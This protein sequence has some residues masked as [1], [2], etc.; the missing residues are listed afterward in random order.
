VR[1]GKWAGNWVVNQGNPELSL[2]DFAKSNFDLLG[3][4]NASILPT[5]LIDEQQSLIKA[6]VNVYMNH[7]FNRLPANCSR[8]ETIFVYAFRHTFI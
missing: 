4:A 7:A 1:L 8:F 6:E 2:S 5:R 3:P